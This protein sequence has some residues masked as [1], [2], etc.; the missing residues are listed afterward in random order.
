MK[1]QLFLVLY[2][3]N[4]C[5]SQQILQKSQLSSGEL[6]RIAPLLHHDSEYQRS[7]I[8]TLN[9]SKFIII[10]Y[11]LRQAHKPKSDTT[12]FNRNKAAKQAFLLTL[13]SALIVAAMG[14]AGSSRGSELVISGPSEDSFGRAFVL[15]SF[16]GA[17]LGFYSQKKEINKKYTFRR[18]IAFV[19]VG[20]ALEYAFF[21]SFGVP[22]LLV[23]F[24]LP[25]VS[26]WLSL[27]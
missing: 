16:L 1:I 27:R 21:K 5:F 11:Q 3:A 7:I 12:T 19:A 17:S 8:P 4:S 18:V 6:N 13:P 14:S 15:G 2:I 23:S 26:G 25:A 9:H 10:N 22:G 24:P 20:G